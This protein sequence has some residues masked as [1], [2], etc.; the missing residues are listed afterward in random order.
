VIGVL[1]ALK[2]LNIRHRIFFKSLSRDALVCNVL[3]ITNIH[4]LPRDVLVC[5]V[6]C[7]TYIHN[8]SYPLIISFA[9]AQNTPASY[10][11]TDLTS[12]QQGLHLGVL[13]ASR[14]PLQV[15]WLNMA[16]VT[17]AK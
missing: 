13:D 6:S 12:P 2:E 11:A 3:C 1:E 7:I 5:N 4:N 10:D 17:I 15:P 14:A 8:L 9:F 16:I